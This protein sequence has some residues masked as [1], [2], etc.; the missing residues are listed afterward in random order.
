MRP[1]LNVDR[2]DYILFGSMHLYKKVLCDFDSTAYLF[3]G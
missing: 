3:I 2:S 1:L